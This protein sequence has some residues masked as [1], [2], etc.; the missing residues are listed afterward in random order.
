V[1]SSAARTALRVGESGR[2]ASSERSEAV[3][4]GCVGVLDV[5]LVVVTLLAGG[6][7]A[8]GPEGVSP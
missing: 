6:A 3:S 1:Q 7:A 8:A 4:S 5:L 2:Q